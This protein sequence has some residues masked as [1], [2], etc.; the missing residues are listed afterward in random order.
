M[1]NMLQ[2]GGRLRAEVASNR[3]RATLQAVLKRTVDVGALFSDELARYKGLDA[4]YL[5]KVINYATQN[6][7]GLVHTNEIENFWSLL[8]RAFS[9]MYVSFEPVHLFRY[10]D[11]P[12]YR[13]NET[14]ASHV[15]LSPTR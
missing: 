3:K 13:F 9:G 1:R 15:F 8:K 14:N 11:E 4:L 5:H 10:L 7:D 6:V 12:A 2:R